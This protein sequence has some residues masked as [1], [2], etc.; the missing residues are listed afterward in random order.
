MILDSMN[1]DGTMIEFV[2]FNPC[3]LQNE[4][5]YFCQLNPGHTNQ[6]CATMSRSI[7][8]D[9]ETYEPIVEMWPIF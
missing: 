3:Q 4:D 7:G 6:H 2:I 8:L 9:P 1:R 5:G